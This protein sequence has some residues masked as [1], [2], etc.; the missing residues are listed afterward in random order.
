LKL[1]ILDVCF[2]N[3]VNDREPF[4]VTDEHLVALRKKGLIE[5]G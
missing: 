4:L 1:P 2:V 5:D 3:R